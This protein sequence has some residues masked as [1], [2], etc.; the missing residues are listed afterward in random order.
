MT[1]PER[2]VDATRMV[3]FEPLVARLGPSLTASRKARSE[4]GLSHR[5]SHKRSCPLSTARPLCSH[6]CVGSQTERFD[7]TSA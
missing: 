1:G 2:A 6:M 4:A 3:R 7:P 5:H